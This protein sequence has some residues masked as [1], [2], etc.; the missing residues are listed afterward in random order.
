MQDFHWLSYNVIPS[1][2]ELYLC[3]TVGHK[4]D[5]LI[6]CSL[7]ISVYLKANIKAIINSYE[8]ITLF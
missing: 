4:F 2:I 8:N 1:M 3:F 5:I 7:R 6:F